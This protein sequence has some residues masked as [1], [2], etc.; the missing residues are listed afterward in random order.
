MGQ[1]ASRTPGIGLVLDTMARTARRTRKSPFRRLSPL[2]LHAVK[3][4][5]I[6]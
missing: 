5:L 1:H 2:L 4:V 6:T 3:A